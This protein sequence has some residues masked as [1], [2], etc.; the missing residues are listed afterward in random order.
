MS[1]APPIAALPISAPPRRA[2]LMFARA[3]LARLSA[4]RF[5]ILG[6]A[7]DV[8]GVASAVAAIFMT[9]AFGGILQ[10]DSSLPVLI[11]ARPIFYR[12]TAAYMY[13]PIVRAAA[14]LTV[15]LPWLAAI[16][17]WV[18]P[19]GY[20]MQGLVGSAWVAPVPGTTAAATFFFQ[21][22]VVFTLGFVFVSL[23]QLVAAVMPTFDLAQAVVGL[24]IPIL[25]LFGGLFQPPSLMPPGTRWGQ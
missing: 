5:G 24:L 10:M 23:G 15:E 9:A 2:P 22:F 17:L 16:L 20:F 3:S 7:T 6:A 18:V 25:F 12:E 21:Y 1:R 19:I 13:D 11:S 14:L 4:R 8:A